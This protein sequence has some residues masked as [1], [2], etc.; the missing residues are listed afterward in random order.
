MWHNLAMPIFLVDG[1]VVEDKSCFKGAC[2]GVKE[3]VN[4]L[5]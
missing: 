2:K 4:K 5:Q 3:D 1:V